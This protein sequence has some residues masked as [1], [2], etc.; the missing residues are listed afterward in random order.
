M[1]TVPSQ[2]K[3]HAYCTRQLMKVWDE[4]DARLA[5]VPIIDKLNRGKFRIDDYKLWLLNH[6]QQV[7]EGARWIT[8]AA[9][10]ITEQHAGLRA[11]FIKHAAT[12][13]ND[14]R[15]LEQSYISLGGTLEEMQSTP[16]NIGSEALSAYM[17]HHAS[18]PDPFHL[19]GAMFIIE[20]L[21]QH[22]AAGWGAMIK[23][24]LGLE[25]KQV[26]F[27]TYH[28]EHDDDHM[29]EL[30]DVLASGLLEQE[31]MADAIIRTAKIVARLYILQLE[32]I[33][34]TG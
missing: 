1:N 17:F 20:G 26:A 16:K 6:R 29:Q 5:S 7:V 12:E 18:Q 13:H 31:G 24:Q 34:N 23:E 27:L 32:E 19:L 14:Y 10:S 2:I 9:S 22:K 4:F 28:G 30:E 3:D 33:G 8:R 15:M 21:G 25:D 11:T